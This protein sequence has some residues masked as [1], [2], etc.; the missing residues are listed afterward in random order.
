MV[1][2]P[3]ERT[4]SCEGRALVLTGG[5]ARGAYQAGALRAIAAICAERALPFPIVSGV[6]AGAINAAFL[7]IHADDF[8]RATE[9]LWELWQGLHTSDVFVTKMGALLRNGTRL[10]AELT[11]GALIREHRSNHLLDTGPL[12]DLVLAYRSDEAIRRHLVEGRLRAIAVTATDYRSGN[13]VTFYDTEAP[14]EP[15]TRASRVGVHTRIHP[16]HVLASAALP[17]FFPPVAVDGRYFGDG[18]IR[19]RAPLST[20][21]HLGAKRI[22]AIGTRHPRTALE[23]VEMT[24]GPVGAEA[25]PVASRVP[26]LAEIG[27]VLLNA[28]LLDGLEVDVERFERINRT[29]AAMP[30]DL[31]SRTPLRVIP[32]TVL[33]PSQDLG[34]LATELLHRVP[35][36]VRHLLKGLGATDFVGWDLLSYLFFDQAYTTKLLRLGHDDTIA[37]RESIER[38]L[39]G[40]HCPTEP[41]LTAQDRG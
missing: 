15:W 1:H 6:S 27:G 28:L 29:L 33:R 26:T 5:G 36:P 21:I 3:L 30:E 11:L 7:A 34:E 2:L 4:G 8:S 19:L 38:F 22:L 32:L 9:A 31:Q 39:S 16:E 25:G 20:V 37:Q 12:R 35:L 24:R 18:G 40:I 13:A 23:T 17:L 14:I 41:M 10:L